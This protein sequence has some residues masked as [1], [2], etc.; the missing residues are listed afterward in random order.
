MKTANRLMRPVLLLA[1]MTLLASCAGTAPTAA[2]VAP[3]EA[4]KA[5]EATK[6]AELT[7]A[8][9]PTAAAEPT[10]A[11]EAAPAAMKYSE[12]P[13]LTELVKAGKLPPLEERLPK[14]PLVVKP[15]SLIVEADLPNW[16]PGKYGGTLRSAH[17]V[18]N[19]APDIFMAQI[20]N[21]LAAPG[22][23]IIGLQPNLVQDYKVS[24]DNKTFTFFMREGLKW[25]D[26]QPVTTED[27]QF[28]YEDI[29]L[30]EKLTPS[31]PQKFRDAGNPDGKPMKL[32][33]E[34]PYQF[35]ITFGESYGGFLREMAIKGWQAYTD[36][37][38]PKHI[39]KDFHVTYTSMEKLKPMLDEKK[40]GEEWWTL[41]NQKDCVNWELTNPDCVGF[42]TLYPWMSVKGPGSGTLLWERNPYYFKVDTEG[43]Q[44]PYIDKI[45]SQQSEN[46]EA[47]NLRVL[48]GEVDFLRESTA[49]VKVPLYKENQQKIDINVQLLDMHVGSTVLFLNLNYSDTNWTKVV[50]DLRFRKA[51]NLAIPRKEIIETIY[52]EYATPPTTVSGETNLDEAKKLL[53]EM[54]LDKLDADGFRL[55]PDGKTF[56]IPIEHGAH[57]PDIAP[58]SEL[59]AEGLK[60]VGLKTT[61]NRPARRVRILESSGK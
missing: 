40:L 5:A 50:N 39:L 25:S 44:L 32:E 31:F 8:P 61:D 14:E 36:L 60:T 48:A 45:I 55:G 30:N 57:A 18:P 10:K 46:V 21:L 1:V 47:V 37:F 4:P 13:M 42:P 35:R 22:I 29:L 54:G 11:A 15:G 17:S 26:G 49:L 53:D 16:T 51:V 41:F 7:K 56:V 3:T 24:D 6:P 33:V 20:E 38:K 58:A 27:V 12:S 23:G 34:G 9:E 43:K 2:P 19:W 28:A 59:V 52:F